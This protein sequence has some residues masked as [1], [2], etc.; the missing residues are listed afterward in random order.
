VVIPI[1]DPDGRPIGV[2]D[3]DSHRPAHFDDAD[4]EGYAAVV[5]L[6]EQT[7]WPTGR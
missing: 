2:L 1:C 3:V 4:L 7:W 5:R 6:L